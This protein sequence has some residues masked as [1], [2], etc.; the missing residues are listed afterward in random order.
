[1]LCR[2]PVSSTLLWAGSIFLKCEKWQM[3]SG[4]VLLPLTV[5]VVQHMVLRIQPYKIAAMHF[6][7]I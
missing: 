3:G 5:Y 7:V 4:L 2:E 6:S 1:M